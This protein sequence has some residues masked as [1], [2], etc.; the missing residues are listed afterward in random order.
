MTLTPDLLLH[1]YASG[2]FPM[3]ES[4]DDG[5]LFWVDPKVRAIIPLDGFHLPR[6]LARTVRQ[7][8]F[9]VRIDTAF[10]PVMEACAGGAGGERRE[11]WIN[12]TI[13][14]LYGA[15]FERGVCHSVECWSGDELVGGLYG[16]HLGAAFF[17]ESMFSRAT[18]ASKVALVYLVARLIRGG[19]TLLDTQFLTPHLARFGCVEISRDVYHSRLNAALANKNADY[20]ALGV[21]EAPE[22]ILQ[23][24]IHR[25]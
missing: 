10:R 4:R 13:L 21:D 15:L 23:S 7:G 8:K 2:I 22:T 11:S 20:F 17:G 14:R 5:D 9:S 18:D 19:F 6:R 16:L 1:A 3:A 24:L 12:D 25:S